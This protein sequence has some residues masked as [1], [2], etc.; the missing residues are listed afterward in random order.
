M[1][2]VSSVKHLKSV[3]STPIPHPRAPR[4][5]DARGRARLVHGSVQTLAQLA[6]QK[7]A[8]SVRVAAHITA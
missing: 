3:C 7:S 1:T 5:R 8:V 6:F 4:D 2:H